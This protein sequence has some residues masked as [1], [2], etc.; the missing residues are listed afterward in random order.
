VY[1][2]R[3]ANRKHFGAHICLWLLSAT[4]LALG[5]QNAYGQTA[6]NELPEAKQTTLG[7]YVTAKEA[8]E[9]WRAA[10]DK[11]KILDVRTP[12]EYIFVGHAPTAVNIPAFLQTYEW[13]DEKHHYAMK[14][15]PDFMS[16]VQA[17]FTPDDT[18]YVMCR[19]GGRSAASVNLLA[20]AGFKHVYNITDGMEGDAVAEPGS[21]YSGQRMKNGWKNSGVP[22]TY[23]LDPRLMRLPARR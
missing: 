6:N 1:V 3:H 10:P 8:Y 12:E 16:Q 5:S 11:V 20:A 7:L 14:P 9:L 18:V 4:T 23:A 13:D 21:L 15:N 22:W 17:T 19:S 2:E